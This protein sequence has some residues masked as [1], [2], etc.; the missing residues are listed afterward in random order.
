[1]R[2][3]DEYWTEDVAIG[4]GVF[5][6]HAHTLRLK[7]HQSSERFDV[8]RDREL[9]PLAHPRGSRLYFLAKPY[10]LLPDITLSINLYPYATPADQGAIGEVAS[11]SW[12][13]MKHE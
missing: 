2:E 3:Q 4:D 1:M 6:Q 13:G 10:I 9:V 11:S 8:S 5:Y 12:Q 7:L